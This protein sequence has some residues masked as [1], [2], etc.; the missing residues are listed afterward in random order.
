MTGYHLSSP[1]NN[2]FTIILFISQFSISVLA[3]D[4]K[5]TKDIKTVILCHI[6]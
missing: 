1:L 3:N 4:H 2:V 5:N 6:S